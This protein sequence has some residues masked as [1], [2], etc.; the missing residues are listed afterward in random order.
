M[1][2]TF[3]TVNYPGLTEKEAKDK[4]L[5]EGF[6][7]LP[8][9][10]PKNIFQ[11]ALGVVKEPMFLLLVACGTLYLILGD[12]QEGLMLLGFVFV[13]MGIEFYQEKKT[14]KALDALKDLA[15][16]RALVIRDGERKRIPGREVVTDDIVFLQEG[17]RVPAD[18]LVLHASAYWQMNPCYR[19][20]CSGKKNGNGKEADNSFYP[21][22]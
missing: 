17:D 8:S 22:W 10:K 7:E 18:A 5:S 19:R 3:K 11:I 14:E 9:S 12:I 20:I 16:P 13:V 1:E 21:G 2:A 15:S 4:L 6:N